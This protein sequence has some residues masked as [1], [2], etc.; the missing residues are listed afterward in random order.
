[1]QSNSLFEFLQIGEQFKKK[2]IKI[3]V[4]QITKKVNKYFQFMK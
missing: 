2:L 4:K 1:M 3:N